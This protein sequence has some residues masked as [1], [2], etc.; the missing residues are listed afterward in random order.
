VDDRVRNGVDAIQNAATYFSNTSGILGI[1]GMLDRIGEYLD[2]ADR[3]T[4]NYPFDEETNELYREC[5]E[6]LQ[7]AQGFTF[8]LEENLETLA[9]YMKEHS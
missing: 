9:R 5:V 3:V 6:N 1:I 7:D 2:K 4:G 8:R